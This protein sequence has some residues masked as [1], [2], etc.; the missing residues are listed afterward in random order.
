M[1]L[2]ISWVVWNK[3]WVRKFEF[4]LWSHPFKCDQFWYVLIE[5]GVFDA[6]CCV[7]DPR[8]VLKWCGLLLLQS[9]MCYI[10]TD[11]WWSVHSIQNCEIRYQT[12][13]G[14]TRGGL[15]FRSRSES[16]RFDISPVGI[17]MIEMHGWAEST[18]PLIGPRVPLIPEALW[19]VHFKRA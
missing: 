18:A 8:P 3:I 6:S 14:A 11:W 9:W 10:K 4:I 5:W 19:D 7:E 2:N 1:R 15:G 16:F 17:E 12:V 13:S